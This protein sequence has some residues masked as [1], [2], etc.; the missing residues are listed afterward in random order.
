M[1][2]GARREQR[3]LGK[4][5]P[6][7]RQRDHGRASD[8][9]ADDGVLGLQDRIDAFDLDLLRDAADLELDGNAGDLSGLE[10]DRV[11]RGFLEPGRLR[12]NHVCSDIEPGDRVDAGVVRRRR[13]LNTGCVIGRRDGRAAHEAPV[14]SVTVPVTL[15]VT[16]WLAAGRAASANRIASATDHGHLRILCIVFLL[17]RNSL[18]ATVVLD[19]NPASA[20]SPPC[21]RQALHH[22]LEKRTGARALRRAA[23]DVALGAPG[24]APERGRVVAQDQSEGAEDDLV[25][26]KADR[27]RRS[28]RQPGARAR[29]EAS[30][31]GPA[32]P[33]GRGCRSGSANPTRSPRPIP[34][35]VRGSPL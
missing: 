29:C 25:V 8:D 21:G 4:V 15:A 5:A 31:P 33:G 26:A 13:G 17:S 28:P 12:A 6:V 19:G 1:R 14:S 35:R 20:R 3:E 10:L 34:H 32:G 24:L 23:L 11:R 27:N 9:L 30:R 16:F 2:L 22:T 18:E 7:Q